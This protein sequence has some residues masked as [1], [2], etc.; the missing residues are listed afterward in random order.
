[1]GRTPPGQTRE[2]VFRLVRDRLLAGLPPTV[3][4]VQQAFRFRSVQTAREH[5]EAL[6]E[7]GLLAKE[8]GKVAKELGII[9]SI[10]APYYINLCNPEKADASMKTPSAS[11]LA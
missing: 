6:V 9:L 2:R 1:M 4:E 8:A 5:L 10:H 7:Q 3:R 11:S